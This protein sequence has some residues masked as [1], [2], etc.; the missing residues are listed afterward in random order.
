MILHVLCELWTFDTLK[1]LN[2]LFSCF[3]GILLKDN[4]FSSWLTDGILS[5]YSVAEEDAVNNILFISSVEACRAWSW[6]VLSIIF[7][8]ETKIWSSLGRFS[9]F[10]FGCSDF[11]V[12]RFSCCL[13]NGFLNSLFLSSSFL[14]LFLISGVSEGWLWN[15]NCLSCDGCVF[16]ILTDIQES[17]QNNQAGGRFHF[18][19]FYNNIIR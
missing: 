10:F 19:D 4:L 17:D 2:N 15:F 16:L 18:I 5:L 1:G 3:L 13:C 8:I 14:L 12:G 11:L 6:G 7:I 9:F